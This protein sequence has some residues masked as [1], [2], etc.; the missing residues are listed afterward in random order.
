MSQQHKINTLLIDLDFDNKSQGDEFQN[1]AAAFMK[2]HILP[3]VDQIFDQQSNTDEVI[4]IDTLEINLG[5][6]EQADFLTQIERKFK[7]ELTQKLKDIIPRKGTANALIE[8]GITPQEKVTIVSKRDSLLE[9]L[10][11]YLQHGIVAWNFEQSSQTITAT[12][13]LDNNR[14]S[15]HTK[16]NTHSNWLN[17]AVE[18]QL[19]W[20]VTFLNKNPPE[21]P[22]IITR[23]FHQLSPTTLKKLTVQLLPQQQSELIKLLDLYPN[24][25]RSRALTAFRDTYIKQHS[26]HALTTNK[27]DG[28]LANYE[29][30]S[31]EIKNTYTKSINADDKEGS[32]LTSLIVQAINE[33]SPQ[34]IESHWAFIIKERPELL[35]QQIRTYAQSSETQRKLVKTFSD[36]MLKG[37]IEALEPRDY[38]FILQLLQHSH[39]VLPVTKSANQDEL[40]KNRL[41][42]FSLEYLLVERG[43]EFN[44]TSYLGSVLKKIA[45]HEN[46]EYPQLLA[47]LYQRISHFTGS[48]ELQ[49]QLLT[50]LQRLGQAESISLSLNTNNEHAQSLEKPITSYLSK[51]AT[52]AANAFAGEVADNEVLEQVV[53]ALLQGNEK[54]I[55]RYWRKLI[56]TYPSLLKEL[57][58]YH[59]QLALVRNKL[60]SG[61][62]DV[63]LSD[64]IQLL[65]PQVKGFILSV[66]NKSGWFAV[67]AN[68]KQSNLGAASVRT[69]PNVSVQPHLLKQSMWE[70]T[71]SYLLVERGSQF[72]KKNYLAS[73]LKQMA[74]HHNSDYHT[75]LMS[76]AA[77][78]KASS[79]LYN[80]EWVTLLTDLADSEQCHAEKNHPNQSQAKQVNLTVVSLQERESKSYIAVK[81][82]KDFDAYLALY[83]YFTGKQSQSSQ[84]FS[85]N[86]RLL[87]MQN[88]LLLQRLLKES[89]AGL[90]QWQYVVNLL[91][92]NQRQEL[93]KAFVSLH[94]SGKTL[95]A[96]SESSN[97]SYF[98][99]AVTSQVNRC[100][101]SS[102]VNYLFTLLFTAVAAEQPVDFEQLNQDIEQASQS[103]I[104]K[105]NTP[106]PSENN[107][108]KGYSLKQEHGLKPEKNVKSDPTPEQFL[109]AYFEQHKLSQHNQENAANKTAVQ[110]AKLISSIECLLAT[111]HRG[112]KEILRNN[113]QIPSISA[114]L[115][116]YLPE[117][118]LIKL[119]MLLQ[120]T[121]YANVQ[122]YSRLLINACYSDKQLN[123]RFSGLRTALEKI[124]Y[125]HIFQYLIVEGRSFNSTEFVI[126]FINNLASFVTN[127]STNITSKT[128][129]NNVTAELAVFISE[130]LK[131][132]NSLVEQARKENIINILDTGATNKSLARKQHLPD[133]KP[134][135][136]ADA[137]SSKKQSHVLE[138]DL[139]TDVN[140]DLSIKDNKL[141]NENLNKPWMNNEQAANES[142]PISI[143]NAGL[144]LAT[145]YIPR[146]FNMLG[147]TSHGAFKQPKDAHRAIHL[148]QYMV[149]G[150]SQT[151]EYQLVLNKLLCGIKI[152]TPVPYQ[153]DI[154]EQ[155]KTTIEGM[156]NAIIQHWK[157]L[158]ST[159]VSGLQQTFIQRE[160][161]LI[162]QEK[163]WAL[164]V[165]QSTFDMLLD[166]IPWSYSLIKFPWM[167]QPLHVQWR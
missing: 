140:I 167:E 68:A 100:S 106:R 138:A 6:I 88:N 87:S 114:Y 139:K 34:V 71:L 101:S 20:L 51:D 35:A 137:N 15:D 102:K 23:L 48:S 129:S 95:S 141:L 59:G 86:L 160:G 157:A 98:M 164:T 38:H 121:D 119:V 128:T 81:S 82:L 148:L 62:S 133:V 72:N 33:A 31:T 36:F 63:L 142:E 54:S 110:Q 70:F 44:K 37:I 73:L 105:H 1:T 45:A 115:S 120:P 8:Y 166:Q 57:L 153:V 162:S 91:T 55:S 146:L 159:S 131:V 67:S 165:E 96:T 14:K 108:E 53:T 60:A 135:I 41:W 150:S 50:L 111:N 152:A 156:L 143:S 24:T 2:Q 21:S 163:A 40:Q 66:I 127:A 52:T 80:S 79:S 74:A 30:K 56:V 118:L 25:E 144:V 64:I 97:L 132:S 136:S 93:L 104:D 4:S 112:L 78:I 92:N 158:G 145:P 149:N 61:F 47:V 10:A 7:A 17:E 58:T 75:L 126:R 125:Q 122:A 130:Q 49:R 39:S 18:Q 77:S 134:N 90:F 43:S 27:V 94:Y 9:Q 124:H 151:P 65:T 11:F 84:Q 5:D 12:D 32:Q 109:L 103:T 28:N 107:I 76:M 16:A 161:T 85:Y 116:Q 3:A 26:E 123:Q 147:L 99:Q 83:A 155:E 69:T 29:I 19:S 117:R 46:S 113:M 13:R 42:E 89:H 154:S 22:V